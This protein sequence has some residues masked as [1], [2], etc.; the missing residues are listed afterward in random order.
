MSL[1]LESKYDPV[2]IFTTSQPLVLLPGLIALLLYP[3]PI[4]HVY[5]QARSCP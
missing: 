4:Y 3:M 5:D 1:S 2:L